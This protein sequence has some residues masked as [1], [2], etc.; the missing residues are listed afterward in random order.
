MKRYM[1]RGGLNDIYLYASDRIEWQAT[2]RLLEGIRGAHVLPKVRGRGD[3]SLGQCVSRLR[4]LSSQKFQIWCWI[5]RLE[6]PSSDEYYGP[7]WLSCEVIGA[8]GDDKD[9]VWCSDAEVLRMH[10]R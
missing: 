6:N 7:D 8:S 2:E 9:P 10:K 4:C 5:E 3:L 1:T